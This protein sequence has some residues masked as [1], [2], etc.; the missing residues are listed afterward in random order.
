[1]HK[2]EMMKICSEASILKST[3]TK[4]MRQCIKKLMLLTNSPCLQKKSL[5]KMNSYLKY[6]FNTQYYSKI[7]IRSLRMYS[8]SKWLRAGQLMKIS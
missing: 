8:R 1:M 5:R 6:L 2:L 4:K 7:A 3:L